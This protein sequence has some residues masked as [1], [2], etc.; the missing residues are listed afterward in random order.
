MF[1]FEEYEPNELPTAPPRS[2]GT[3]SEQYILVYTISLYEKPFQLLKLRCKDIFCF[4]VV[5][6]SY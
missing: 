5:Q 1:F 4:F 3:P 6:I 2:E